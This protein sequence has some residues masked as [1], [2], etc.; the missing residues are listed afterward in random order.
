MRVTA[1]IALAG[2]LAC[3]APVL[4][5]EAETD[6]AAFQRLRA[7]AVAAANADDLAT[8]EQKLAEADA[9]IPNHPG[10]MLMR[11][12][13]AAAAGRPAD[14]VALAQRYAD[15]GLSMN[16][17]GDPALAALAEQPGF[18]ALEAA[19][20][21]NR[22][23]AGADRLTLLA[24][25]PGGG[26]VES[27]ARD[28]ARGRWLVAQVRGRTIVALDDAGAVAPFL[29]GAEL[30]GVLGLVMDAPAGVLWA[31]TAPVPPAVN[32]L[33]EGVPRPG[34]ALLKID[35]ASGRVLAR[36]PAP[37]DNGSLGD[38]ALG[39]DGTVYAAGGDLFQ[40]RPGGEALEVLLPSGP[41]RSPQGMA[42]TPDG[43]ALIV[44]DY[45][46]GIWR[47]DR[48]SGAAVRLSAPSNASLIGIDGLICDG[49]VLYALQNGTAPQRVLRL[50]PDPD[51]SR[52]EAV[53]VL[54]ANLPE[55]VEPTT[56]LVHNGE[57]VFVS[58]SQWSDFD[59]E[60]ALT[61]PEPDPALI[62][63]LRLD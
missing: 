51:W 24:A 46:S 21:A 38:V 57:L 9:R 40:L 4:A 60:G 43:A 5:Q 41:M 36:Y 30:S 12:R 14:A 49:R 63:R 22:T 33:A 29:A 58:R 23:P 50:T 42:L 53:E 17:G 8:A 26:L 35:A 44:A 52:I 3:A 45:S 34:P 48:A 31:A 7:E 62:S 56:G 2:L 6:V 32:G 20:E 19:V 54:A 13:L 25:I 11:A 27:V 39:P 10:L 37:A 16:L 59:R 47:V 15:T 55:I 28:E 61:T 18:A 1:A